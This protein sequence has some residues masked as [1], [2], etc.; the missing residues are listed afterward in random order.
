[1]AEEK[2]CRTCGQKELPPRPGF[3]SLGVWETFC[4]WTDVAAICWI[5]IGVGIIANWLG[6]FG[7]EHFD[8]APLWRTELVLF[9]GVLVVVVVGPFA[10]ALRGGWWAWRWWQNRC[11]P[12]APDLPGGDSGG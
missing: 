5:L 11:R 4:R 3:F 1:M 12:A 6:L 7:P 2:R 9:M 8:T 10:W